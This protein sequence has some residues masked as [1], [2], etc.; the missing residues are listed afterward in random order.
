MDAMKCFLSKLGE[1]YSLQKKL[2]NQHGSAP[3]SEESVNA[4]VEA[5]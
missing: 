2:K 5:V 1:K 3:P 4:V